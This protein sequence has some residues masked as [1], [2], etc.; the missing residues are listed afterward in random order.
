M[1]QIYHTRGTTPQKISRH[2][3]FSKTRPEGH[4]HSEK[5]GLGIKNSDR[6]GPEGQF[7][8]EGTT[9]CNAG[10]PP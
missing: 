6:N 7:I 3:F 10:F 1:V 5:R 9:M 4:D 2:S 8:A